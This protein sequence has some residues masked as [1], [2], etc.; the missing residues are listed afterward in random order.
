MAHRAREPAPASLSSALLNTRIS[1]SPQPLLTAVAHV[2]GSESGVLRV[3]GT[4]RLVQ[5][6][7]FNELSGWSVFTAVSCSELLPALMKWQLALSPH[8]PPFQRLC[9]WH[10]LISL[11]L[12]VR[13][14]VCMHVC[15]PV[16]MY[17]VDIPRPTPTKETAIFLLVT[18][19]YSW[20]FADEKL[21]KETF[22]VLI[23]ILNWR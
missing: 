8:P 20:Q 18:Y 9:S 5:H 10:E 23:E 14:S 19:L 22:I 2:P 16:C 3:R 4:F 7:L 1:S 11:C 15:L 21:F 12:S 13:L 17:V 6:L